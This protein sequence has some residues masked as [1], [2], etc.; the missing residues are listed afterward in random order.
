MRI[1]NDNV[2]WREL[3]LTGWIIVLVLIA[4]MVSGS[5]A[6]AI[7]HVYVS[8]SGND[9]NDGS[10]GSPVQTEAGITRLCA[11]NGEMPDDIDTGLKWANDDTPTMVSVE[12]LELFAGR[13]A[14]KVKTRSTAEVVP[15]H[16]Q[17]TDIETVGS[18]DNG[19]R[20]KSRTIWV[21]IYN[22]QGPQEVKTRVDRH[23]EIY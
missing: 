13:K 21:V 11:V 4:L 9:A 3:I 18:N 10:N 17:L 16:G 20:I 5:R 2:R 22:A 8:D 19:W 23:V 1:K 12:F 15:G 14:D 6:L 7:P